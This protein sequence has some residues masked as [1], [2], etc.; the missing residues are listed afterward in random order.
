MK[1]IVSTARIVES[2]LAGTALGAIGSDLERPP[3][4]CADHTEAIRM[5]ASSALR[6]AAVQLAPH[7]SGADF[8]ADGAVLSFRGAD[9]PDPELTAAVVEHIVAARVLHFFYAC[10]SPQAAAVCA[11]RAAEAMDSLQRM[12]MA[13]LPAPG[14]IVPHG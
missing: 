5:A 3:L 13:A 2:L 12:F 8:D 9:G 14:R 1:V 6:A 10:S 11:A 7:L 4:L